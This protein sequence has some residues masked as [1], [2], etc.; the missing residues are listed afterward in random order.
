MNQNQFKLG[1][2]VIIL[3]FIL[4]ACS[5]SSEET[6]P[7]K[8]GPELSVDIITA[9]IEGQST[10]EI[11]VSAQGVTSPIMY[12]IDGTNFQSS[13]TFAGLSADDYTITMKDANNCTDTEMATVIEI[14][15]VFYANEIRPIIDGNCQIS[16]CHGSNSS[17]PTWATY[18]DVKAKADRI[19]ERTG[20]KSMPQSGSISDEEIKI[21]ADWVDIGAPN[22]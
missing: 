3:L 4:N 6:N 1:G 8:N 7:C 18:A 22:N 9:S 16:G 17:I 21:I 19:K 13:S 11:T 2:I 14:K 10:G 20:N 15:E 5:D 12:S